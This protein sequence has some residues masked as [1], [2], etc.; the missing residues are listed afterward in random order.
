M[1]TS[2][3]SKAQG[4]WKLACW[5][6][7]P[8]IHPATSPCSSLSFPRYNVNS[9]GHGH[10][11][12]WAILGV[13]LGLGWRWVGR[14]SARTSQRERCSLWIGAETPPPNSCASN[15]DHEKWGKLKL[16]Y[17][18]RRKVLDSHTKNMGRLP[19]DHFRGGGLYF[20]YRE[21]CFMTVLF[22]E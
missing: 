14:L 8:I 22:W 1:Y 12:W 9:W 4:V 18:A 20:P 11:A 6:L 3:I 10:L 7:S 5:T 17:S 15:G 19:A 13:K 2:Y 21:I 16:I